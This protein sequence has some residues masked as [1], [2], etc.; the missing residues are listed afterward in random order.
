MR[1][2]SSCIYLFSRSAFHYVCRLDQII[3]IKRSKMNIAYVLNA[4]RLLGIIQENLYMSAPFIHA[5]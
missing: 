4:S 2:Y 1:N 3:V 5:S